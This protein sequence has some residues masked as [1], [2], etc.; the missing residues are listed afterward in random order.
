MILYNSLTNSAAPS[1]RICAGRSSALL[2]RLPFWT[3]LGRQLLATLAKGWHEQMRVFVSWSG[4]RSKAIA[5]VIR[6]WLPGVLQAVRPYFSP[7]DISKGSRWSTEI[8]KELEASRLGLLIL[9]PE[10]LEASWLMFEAGALAKNLDKSKVCPLLFGLDPTDVTGPLVQFQAARFEASEMKRVVKM[11][12]TELGDAGLAVDVLE[13]VFTM[14]WPQLDREVAALVS[15]V[16]A[17][18]PQSRSERDMIEEVLELARVMSREMRSRDGV[19]PGALNDLVE[20]YGQLVRVGSRYPDTEMQ[21]ALRDMFRPLE[22][23]CGRSQRAGPRG[24]SL[25]RLM[26]AREQLHLMNPRLTDD[27]GGKA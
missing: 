20:C 10:N 9:T 11:I 27:D 24:R 1:V 8:G 26:E 2:W 6:K 16:P 3:A 25:T 5:E 13:T 14:W 23:I 15:Q 21:H 18:V 4:E 7:D 19:H 12:N 17:D 22:Y